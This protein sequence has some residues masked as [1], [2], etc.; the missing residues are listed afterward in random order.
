MAK[1]IGI[2]ETVL[3]IIF[4]DDKPQA[5]IPGGSAFNAIVSLGKA[6]APC[7]MVTEVGNDHVGDI[8]CQ[9]LRDNGVATDYIHRAEGYQS[10]ISLAFLNEHND[11]NYQFYKDHTKVT[12]GDN[13]PDIEPDDI[14]LFGSF[15]AITPGIRDEVKALLQKAH[16]MGATLYYDVNFRAS[17]QH[18]LPEV[19]ENIKENMRLATIVRGSTEDF[20]LLFGTKDIDELYEQH[21]PCDIFILT[22]GPNPLQV[23][24]PSFKAAYPAHPIKAVSTIGAGDNFNAGFVYALFNETADV[25]VNHFADYIAMGQRFAADACQQY[26]NSISDLLARQI[27]AN[28]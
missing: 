24:T 9:Y 12:F 2:G 26:G 4:K 3:D 11:A 22:D 1:I 23:R 21:I 14:I 28:G 27:I 7:C 8:T 15:F 17:H 13:I 5:A 18:Q 20:Q 25:D 19:M 16:D 6:G 10:H